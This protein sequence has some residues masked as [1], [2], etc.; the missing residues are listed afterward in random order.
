MNG[1]RAGPVSMASVRQVVA[2]VRGRI[3]DFMILGKAGI[4][5]FVLM[6]VT[7]GYVL[8][9]GTSIPLLL[10]VL[11]G[12]GLVTAGAG[13]L[14]QVIEREFDARMHR[15]R[16]RPLPTGRLSVELASVLGAGFTMTGAAVLWISVG[17]WP[18]ILAMAAWTLYVGV[19]TPMKRFTWWCNVPGAIAGAL[20][21]MIGT[22]A[23][24]GGPDTVGGVLFT[25]LFFWQWP[26]LLSIAWL[27]QDEMVH[28]GFA[29]LPGFP[30]RPR[31][32]AR[33]IAVS[34]LLMI[35][36]AFLPLWTNLARS[37]YLIV[38]TVISGWFGV[39]VYTFWRR[40]DRSRCR[41]LFLASLVYLAVVSAALMLDRWMA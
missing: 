33:Y 27:F 37:V 22:A 13:T 23:V 18:C 36:A 1:Q 14:N 2:H 35:V 11:L 40:P 38:W 31:T 4:N 3:A 16:S 15:T 5:L 21:P 34:S 6:T 39:S 29:P 26:H 30:D 25:I 32:I 9:G 10:W 8:A 19:Y 20:P 24:R 7:L 41:I 28:A 12:T 17:A